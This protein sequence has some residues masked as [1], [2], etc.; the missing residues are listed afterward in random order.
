[1]TSDIEKGDW[2][3]ELMKLVSMLEKIGAFN[4]DGRSTV[5]KYCKTDLLWD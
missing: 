3:G 5:S 4:H 2:F 1:M